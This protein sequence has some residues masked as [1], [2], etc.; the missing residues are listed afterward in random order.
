M[1]GQLYRVDET[2]VHKALPELCELYYTKYNLIPEI[3][4]VNPQTTSTTDI[5]WELE[6]FRES[7]RTVRFLDFLVTVELRPLQLRKGEYCFEFPGGFNPT[8]FRSVG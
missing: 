3:V 8:K 1:F 4:Y 7:K 5:K 2:A 6:T